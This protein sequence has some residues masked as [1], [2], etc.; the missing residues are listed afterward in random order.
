[1]T[2]LKQNEG[3]YSGPQIH[4]EPP[5]LVTLTLW[6]PPVQADE[7]FSVKCNNRT[8][9]IILSRDPYNIYDISTNT[10][11][12]AVTTKGDVMLEWS[13]LEG[14]TP[15]FSYRYEPVIAH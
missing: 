7:T 15:R 5:T 8:G 10:C 3:P 13:W 11:I 9:I 14:H 4:D 2:R 1:M 12:G 6:Y